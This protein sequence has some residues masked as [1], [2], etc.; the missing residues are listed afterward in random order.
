MN[1]SQPFIEKQPSNDLEW[2]TL[3][4]HYGLPTRLLD[5]SLS[6]LIALYFAVEHFDIDSDAVVWCY[7]SASINNCHPESTPLA[8][9][10]V[11]TTEGLIMPKHISPRVTN[12][13]A[14]F[15][16][17]FAPEGTKKFTPL[18]KQ[19]NNFGIFQKVIIKSN[20]KKEIFKQLEFLRNS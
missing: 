7:G 5:W 11:S 19:D 2:L 4:Q 16:I 15:T 12:Q 3:A 6:P 17:H 1:E 18:D 13:S 9:K 14:C 8:R 10:I 20:F